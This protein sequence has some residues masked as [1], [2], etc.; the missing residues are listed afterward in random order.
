MLNKVG[1]ANLLISFL[2]KLE[3]RSPIKYINLPVSFLSRGSEVLFTLSFLK[4]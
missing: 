3:L 1:R 4:K 2:K